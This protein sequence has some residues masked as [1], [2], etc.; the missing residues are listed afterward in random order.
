MCYVYIHEQI[1]GDQIWFSSKI[2]SPQGWLKRSLW[3]QEEDRDTPIR[4]LLTLETEISIIVPV[5]GILSLLV[6]KCLVA[7]LQGQS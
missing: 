3:S 1:D 4:K 6:D 5:V 2:G 7:V